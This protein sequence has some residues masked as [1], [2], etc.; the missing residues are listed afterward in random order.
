MKA[1]VAIEECED[2]SKEASVLASIF[3]FLIISISSVHICHAI[4]N[5]RTLLH[6]GDMDG[7]KLVIL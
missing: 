1:F 6:E 7:A 4:N 5:I 3:T 2:V